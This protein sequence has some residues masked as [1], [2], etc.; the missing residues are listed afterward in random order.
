[1]SW[2][3][4]IAQE[5][6]KDYFKSLIAFVQEDAK[7]YKIYPAHNDV[8]N[9]L[10]YCPLDKVKVVILGQDPY[11]QEGQ[12]H[13]LSFSVPSEII[14]PPSLRNIFK[15]I[16]ND[17]QLGFL[18]EVSSALQPNYF[19]NSGCLIP[20]ARQGVL[21][22]NAILTVRDSQPGSHRNKGWEIFTDTIINNINQIDRPI[23][24]LLWGSFAKN[25]KG[26]LNNPK[27]L[28]LE[29]AHPSP[30]SAHNGFFGCQHFSKTNRF[31]IKNVLTPIDWKL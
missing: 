16:Q 7:T 8:F 30:L 17:L 12:A 24:F 4:I 23:V 3:E 31:L 13:G 27:H 2:K 15:E 28:I 18:K 9:A 11:H 21:L 25:K 22:L 1:M 20:W 6:Q 14:I 26:L 29:A 19:F 5:K 10:E